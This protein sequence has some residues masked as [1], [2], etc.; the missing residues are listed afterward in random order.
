MVSSAPAWA[1]LF[2]NARSIHFAARCSRDIGP[3]SRGSRMSRSHAATHSLTLFAEDS[4]ARTCQAPG[5]VADSA[6]RVAGSGNTSRTSSGKSSH[7]SSSS[8]TSPAAR[9]RGSRPFAETYEDSAIERAPWGFPPPT[10]EPRTSGDASSS[11]PTP[12]RQWGRC[13]VGISKTG[14]GRYSA[15]VRRAAAAVL[16]ESWRVPPRTVEWMMGFPED[17]TLVSDEAWLRLGSK[18][19]A[20]RSYRSARK[21]SGS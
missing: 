10:W 20:T 12:T 16:G 21:S 2:G 13:G 4:P 8:K 18:A 17:W 19:S 7:A 6:A 14:R 9:K 1:P 15:E 3:E 11:L 5:S